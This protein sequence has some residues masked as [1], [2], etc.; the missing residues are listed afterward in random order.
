MENA[1][2]PAQMLM[3]RRFR[4][5]LPIRTS[6][7]ETR[8]RQKVISKKVVSQKKQ[9]HYHDRGTKQ[10]STLEPGLRIRVL[11]GEGKTWR[12]KGVVIKEVASRS[13]MIQTDRESE[14][15]RNRSALTK[16]NE[17]LPKQVMDTSADKLSR[18]TT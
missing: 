14:L 15:R 17:P 1:Y 18:E 12:E 9:K 6:L 7:I 16:T 10:L 11:S 13:F 5:N 4:T 8:T 2:S 3:D